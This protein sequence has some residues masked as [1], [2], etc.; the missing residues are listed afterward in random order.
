MTERT[1]QIRLYADV[2]VEG[3]VTSAMDG[4]QP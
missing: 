2:S 3:L 1:Q 4:T